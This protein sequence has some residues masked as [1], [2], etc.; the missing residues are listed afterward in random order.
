MSGIEVL[1]AILGVVPLI[2]EAYD[3]SDSVLKGVSTL[4][5]RQKYERE[6]RTLRCKL[7]TQKAI[8]RANA[9][10]ITS[11]ISKDRM[12]IVQQFSVYVTLEQGG[13]NVLENNYR[14]DNKPGTL[15]ALFESCAD[16]LQEIFQCLKSVTNVLKPFTKDELAAKQSLLAD[17]GVRLKFAFKQSDIEKKIS[18]LRTLNEDF[19]L[20]R[21]EIVRI[22]NNDGECQE[23]SICKRRGQCSGNG[24]PG[25]Y[26]FKQVQHASS[27]LYRTISE[28]WTCGIHEQHTVHI[29]SLQQQEK[30]A[31]MDPVS[32]MIAILSND[33]SPES[34]YALQFQVEHCQCKVAEDAKTLK[35]ETSQEHIDTA[36]HKNRMIPEA[37]ISMQGPN[38]ETLASSLQKGSREWISGI[39][40]YSRKRVL[41]RTKFYS[42]HENIPLEHLSFTATLKEE[43]P[44]NYSKIP[45]VDLENIPD[46]CNYFT[47]RYITSPEKTCM[48]HIGGQCTE[49]FS[50][51]PA[52]RDVC[53]R[54]TS[55]SEL[56]RKKSED[57]LDQG[58]SLPLSMGLAHSVANAVLQ[59]YS[60]P[61]LPE[62]W[63]SN[64]IYLGMG[65]TDGEVPYSNVYSVYVSL[66]F[67]MDT[68]GKG[69]AGLNQKPI[70]THNTH[71]STT[72][73]FDIGIRNERLFCLGVVL[74]EI[75]YAKS[76]ELLQSST[77]ESLPA[78]RRSNYFVA[79]A[80]SRRLVC[81][82]GLEYVRII[83]KCISCDFG[84]GET[85]MDNDELQSKFMCDVI[86]VLRAAQDTLAALS[87][88]QVGRL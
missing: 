76:W 36:T 84:L 60:S 48:E 66:K 15:Q 78:H 6:L 63:E 86:D 59:F 5:N 34:P 37:V 79:E 87:M 2:V 42:L 71:R 82:M 53:R 27:G 8:F 14:E 67:G 50:L 12:R 81:R 68:K 88:A 16:T 72:K 21:K 28:K 65:N 20:I 30:Y 77:V 62:Q 23:F 49:R 1:S 85:D 55:L 83:R 32:F 73:I 25:L 40:E 33:D 74:L 75:G 46:H 54:Y 45:S 9:S 17:F 80:L 38:M 61:W 22:L 19:V 43:E 13:S 18:G 24:Q 58:L 10:N 31:N 69:V 57:P 11:T 47:E 64:D 35:L 44:I 39:T 52:E 29:L 3:H 4:A 70:G 26:P 41:G 56:I 51:Q 7:D